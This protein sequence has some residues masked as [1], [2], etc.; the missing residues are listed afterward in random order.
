MKQQEITE[1][2]KRLQKELEETKEELNKIR[3]KERFTPATNENYYF[4]SRYTLIDCD[5][6]NPNSCQDKTRYENYNCFQTKE[7]AY[8]KVD[9]ETNEIFIKRK[10]EGIAKRL[11]DGE[12]IDWND[13]EQGKFFIGYDHNVQRL[14]V[15]SALIFE[16]QGTV[17]C[18]SENFLEEAI[19]EIGQQKLIDYLTND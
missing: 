2:I 18:L 5:N 8:E 1:K 6:F 9:A 10:L 19:K 3:T 17:Y 13:H 11:N 7:E 16:T 14:D 15:T 12:E 4:I